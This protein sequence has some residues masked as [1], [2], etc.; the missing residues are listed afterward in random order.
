MLPKITQSKLAEATGG[1]FKAGLIASAIVGGTASKIDG[2]KF[3]NGATTA[4]FVYLFSGGVSLKKL[5]K[6][7]LD[8]VGKVWALPNTAI[9]L[10]WGGLGYV[11][12]ILPGVDMPKMSFGNNAIQFE[13]HPL[14][15]AGDITFGNTI[16]YMKGF[17]PGQPA[18][19]YQYRFEYNA[20]KNGLFYGPLNPEILPDVAIHEKAHTYQY[21]VLGVFYLPVYLLSGG[22]SHNNPLERSA[23]LY[24]LNKGDWWP[25]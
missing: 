10:A 22:I 7:A 16:S 4:S 14:M 2:G 17:G 5:G 24:G 20:W 25:W 3:S 11:A 15:F 1:D 23:D 19:S 21:Q 18:P 13:N 9:G 8:L 12:G 6:D